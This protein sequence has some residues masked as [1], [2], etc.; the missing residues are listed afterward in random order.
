MRNPDGS[1]FRAIQSNCTCPS[2]RIAECDK[3]NVSIQV[4]S[5]VPGSGFNYERKAENALRVAKFLNDHIAEVVRDGGGRFLALG[6]IPMQNV[7]MAIAELRRCVVELDMVGV[8]IGSHICGKSLDDP[9]YEPL[10][11]EIVKLD[12]CCFVHP[13]DMSTA[14]RVQKYWF[15]WLV[16]S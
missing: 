8:Q 10:W 3:D 9:I 15:P 14:D 11:E 13:W 4:L 5:T 12:C 2:V 16:Q 7:D 1:L 6:T